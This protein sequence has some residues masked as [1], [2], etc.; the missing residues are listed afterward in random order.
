[1]RFA[2]PS[3]PRLPGQGTFTPKQYDMHGTHAAPQ[4]PRPNRVRSHSLRTARGPRSACRRWLGHRL[5]R[6][7]QPALMN[8]D[9]QNR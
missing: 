3:V 7:P 5:E 8:F 9:E 6:A 1:L 2:C 4:P